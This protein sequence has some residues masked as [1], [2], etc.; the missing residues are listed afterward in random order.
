MAANLA[1]RRFVVRGT[2]EMNAK[3]VSPKFREAAS[4]IDYHSLR[5]IRQPPL[6]ENEECTHPIRRFSPGEII[7]RQHCLWGRS[8]CAQCLVILEVGFLTPLQSPKLIKAAA[9]RR[10]MRSGASP[11]T[12][13]MKTKLERQD[14]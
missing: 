3:G 2:G 10:D 9:S 7:Q 14:S 1:V 13:G 6:R 12:L 5:S 11:G 8:V 4:W